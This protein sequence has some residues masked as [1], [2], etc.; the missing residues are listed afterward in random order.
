MKEYERWIVWI[1]HQVHTPDW[2]WELVGIPGIDN[3]WEL[4]QK[5][6]A[7]YELLQARSKAQSVEND[8]LAPPAP[9]C[10]CRKAFLPSQDQMFPCQDFREGQLQKTQAYAQALQYWAERVD[11]PMPG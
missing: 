11:L 8:Y 4:A 2:W 7:S 1:G 3:F 10:I 9:K 6:G 5:R